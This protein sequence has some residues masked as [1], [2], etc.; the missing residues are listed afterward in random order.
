MILQA[1]VDKM[2]KAFNY[3]ENYTRRNGIKIINATRG[4]NLRAFERA[5]IDL[6]KL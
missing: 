3:A 1:P 2:D 6:I 4:G 5:D